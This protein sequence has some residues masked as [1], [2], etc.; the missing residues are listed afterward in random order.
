MYT[1]SQA[2]SNMPKWRDPPAEEKRHPGGTHFPPCLNLQVFWSISQQIC[3]EDRT[4]LY[5]GCLRSDYSDKFKAHMT[6]IQFHWFSGKVKTV[7]SV[8]VF[9]FLC[10][11]FLPC[12]H[13]RVKKRCSGFSLELNH[14]CHP[15]S[16]QIDVQQNKTKQKKD[17][18]GKITDA[19]TQLTNATNIIKKKV[20]WETAA[21][22]TQKTKSKR[23]SNLF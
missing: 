19:N 22:Q 23:L 21:K 13:F 17:K 6:N 11:F 5:R 8:L 12:V 16:R 4:G 15:S 18:K 10:C 20:W 1:R 14:N 3:K 9:C 2:W 7:E